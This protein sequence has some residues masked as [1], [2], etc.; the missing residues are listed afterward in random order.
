MIK[1][2]STFFKFKPL[3]RVNSGAIG[4]KK[5]AE[6]GKRLFHIH[7]NYKF[8]HALILILDQL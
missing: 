2:S 6:I 1:M 4:E 7:Y 5:G 3:F 8:K